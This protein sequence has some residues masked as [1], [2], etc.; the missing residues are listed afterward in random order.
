[1]LLQ[2]PPDNIITKLS[3][4][5]P[6]FQSH[7]SDVSNNQC[8]DIKLSMSDTQVK[9]E[10]KTHSHFTVMKMGRLDIKSISCDAQSHIN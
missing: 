4:K 3:K 7:T 1:M 9:N 5:H 8:I 10:T 2:I 6:Y